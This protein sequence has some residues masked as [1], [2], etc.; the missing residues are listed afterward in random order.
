MTAMSTWRLCHV[1]P[2]YLRD[3]YVYMYV[4]I[5]VYTV[6]CKVVEGSWSVR[7][8]MQPVEAGLCQ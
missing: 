5:C 4:S 8:C 7:R 2:I 1:E 6:F 3:V